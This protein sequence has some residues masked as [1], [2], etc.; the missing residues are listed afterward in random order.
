MNLLYA[1]DAVRCDEEAI[2]VLHYFFPFGQCRR[3]PYA[4]IQHVGERPMGPVTGSW[5]IW[6]MDL[7]APYWFN[8]DIKR[9]LKSRCIVIDTGKWPRVAITPE[10]HETVLRIL[11]D[12]IGR[13]AEA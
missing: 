1:D 12:K 9:P 13:P 11:R 3:I 2:T 10:H 6:G 8:A 5:R 7:F 4:A